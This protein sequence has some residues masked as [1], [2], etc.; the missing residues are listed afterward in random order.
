MQSL[1]HVLIVV[2]HILL[3][4]F[5]MELELT[6]PWIRESGLFP[7]A[8]GS[9]HTPPPSPSETAEWPWTEHQESVC[10]WDGWSSCCVHTHAQL[11]C[12][13]GGGR[14][15]MDL[16]YL[17]WY[18]VFGESFSPWS[19]LFWFP[20]PCP[21]LAVCVTMRSSGTAHWWGNPQREPSSPWPWRYVTHPSSPRPPNVTVLGEKNK[22]MIGNI[23]NTKQKREWGSHLL[24]PICHQALRWC[25]AQLTHSFG[26]WKICSK[27][28]TCEMASFLNT[29]SAAAKSYPSLYCWRENI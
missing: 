9:D 25:E 14:S 4:S 13:L 17:E 11:L 12:W 26:K 15:T 29:E 7:I 2:T 24:H 19:A 1:D 22:Y 8:P 20:L 10:D 21:R 18:S 28:K 27:E 3:D 6:K 5:C 23:T 16:E